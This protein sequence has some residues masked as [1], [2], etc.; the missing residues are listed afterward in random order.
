MIYSDCRKTYTVP[1]EYSI[2]LLSQTLY[3]D[4]IHVGSSDSDSRYL[5]MG[6]LL[7]RLPDSPPEIEM[8]SPPVIFSPML[9]PQHEGGDSESAMGYSCGAGPSGE[10]VLHGGAGP[11]GLS[12]GSVLSGGG[13]RPHGGGSAMS[14]RPSPPLP[15]SDGVPGGSGG[16]GGAG[17]PS[18]GESSG[19]GSHPR[20]KKR[21]RRRQRRRYRPYGQNVSG[22]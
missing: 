12:G 16:D 5:G 6:V 4:C 13:E 1:V 11:S 17:G 8:M 18:G 10:H 19:N 21:P 3:N 7:A 20:G 22:D 15:R 9:S 2:N 14:A